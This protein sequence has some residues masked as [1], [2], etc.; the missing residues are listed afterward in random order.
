MTARLFICFLKAQ[1]VGA[2]ISRKTDN[3]FRSI[4]MTNVSVSVVGLVK[5]TVK[6]TSIMTYENRFMFKMVVL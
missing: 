3:I 2:V 6:T 1:R 4:V 5:I